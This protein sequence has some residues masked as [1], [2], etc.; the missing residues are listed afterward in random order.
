M[1]PC[2]AGPPKRRYLASMFRNVPLLHPTTRLIPS[3]LK[4][5][6]S[7]M[8]ESQLSGW[9]LNFILLPLWLA[10]GLV[11]YFCHRRTH[12]E[13]TSGATESWLHLAQFGS[14][15]A[16]M[17]VVLLLQPTFASA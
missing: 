9:L 8:S 15:A 17:A 7:T 11:D 2:I 13:L 5:D 14:L 6:R 3:G 10:A 16:A 1:A 4:L 12:I